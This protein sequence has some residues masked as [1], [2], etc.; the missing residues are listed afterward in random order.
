MYNSSI[1]I[2]QVFNKQ[3][4]DGVHSIATKYNEQLG[5]IHL[6]NDKGE[7]K[8]VHLN[9]L[10]RWIPTNREN[11]LLQHINN[12]VYKANKERY[13]YDIWLHVDQLQYTTYK[14][15]EQAEFPTHVD[16]ILSGMASTQKLTVIIGLTDSSEYEGGIL[17]IVNGH[18]S[19]I[20]IKLTVGQVL[21]FPSPM[22]HRVTPIT[23]G[24]R[25]TLVTWYCGPMWR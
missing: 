10:Q 1:Y 15:E 2:K 20:D 25:Q 8:I 17:Q 19:T 12:V 9:Y 3:W 11:K 18:D 6:H 22:P 4:A 13:G 7:P 24:T 14:S 5:E 23:K 16:S 21:I